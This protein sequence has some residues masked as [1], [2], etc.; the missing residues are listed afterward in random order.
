MDDYQGGGSS[1]RKELDR[2]RRSSLW[3]VILCMVVA[4]VVLVL[5]LHWGGPTVTVLPEENGLTVVAAD[6]TVHTLD[7][8]R[9]TS[10]ELCHD[11]A[12]FDRG[13]QLNGESGR[14]VT[15]GRFRN[16]QFDEYELHVMEELQSYVVARDSA[17]VLVFNYESDETTESLYTYLFEN[18]S[19]GKTA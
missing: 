8:S 16:A 2:T 7:F 10:V 19:D 6:G 13:E 11:L 12:Q 1:I 9:L 17:G 5:R 15:S 3:N 18:L 4:A 14:S